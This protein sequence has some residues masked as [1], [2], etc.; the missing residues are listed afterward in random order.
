LNRSFSASSLSKARTLNGSIDP[1]AVNCYIKF[2]AANEA[3]PG[4]KLDNPGLNVIQP[5]N[6]EYPTL[7]LP[8]F[9]ELEQ[10]NTWDPTTYVNVWIAPDYDFE[11]PSIH[12]NEAGSFGARGLSYS[13]FIEE[14]FELPGLATRGVN[15]KDP[16]PSTLSHGILLRSGSVLFEHP[17]YLIN[18]MAYYLGVFDLMTF[19][20]RFEGDY[21]PDTPNPDLSKPIFPFNE[22]SKCDGGTFFMTNH[23]SFGRRYTHFSY[24]QRERM[25]FVLE[26]GLYRPRKN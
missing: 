21:C 19:D 8:N 4:R 15:A 24:D 7:G 5:E 1:N 17:D 26:H 14:G 3:P 11:F 16:D 10:A 9:Q 6:G 22:V 2:V 13:P 18:R 23:M 12:P 20:C 25:H